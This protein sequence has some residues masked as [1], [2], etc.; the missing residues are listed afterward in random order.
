M[1][2]AIRWNC[3]FPKVELLTNM[4]FHLHL[5]GERHRNTDDSLTFSAEKLKLILM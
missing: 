2:V 4:Q 5:L 3:I 1:D